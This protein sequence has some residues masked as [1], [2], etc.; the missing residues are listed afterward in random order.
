MCTHSKVS[1]Q[2]CRSAQTIIISMCAS[3]KGLSRLQTLV[4]VFT[5]SVSSV[6]LIKQSIFGVFTCDLSTW[7][8]CVLWVQEMILLTVDD[9]KNAKTTD[10]LIYKCM[11]E[12]VHLKPI[13][14]F[15]KY[16]CQPIRHLCAPSFDLTYHTMW[17]SR[18]RSRPVVFRR[19]GTRGEV[20]SH[21]LMRPA[22]WQGYRVLQNRR[23]AG[24]TYPLCF[25]LSALSELLIVLMNILEESRNGGVRGG[26][27]FKGS[28]G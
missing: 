2:Y 27:C 9:L 19:R 22:R 20:R 26:Y 18:P 12:T 25:L 28:D 21:R 10:H 23:P 17:V 15:V 5:A 7:N 14:L 4:G 3:L 13:G 1:L 8:H 11:C 16:V 6:F 24:T